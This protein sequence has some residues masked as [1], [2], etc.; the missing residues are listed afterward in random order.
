M[1]AAPPEVVVVGSINVDLVTFADHIPTD[2]ETITGTRFE[3]F[4]GGKGANQAV[5]AARLGAQVA[6]IGCVG[7]DDFGRR[8]RATL[9]ADG[10]DLSSVRTVSGVSTGV[11][12]ITVAANGAN[13]IVVI[14]GANAA[15][16][17]DD[18]GVLKD[19]TA[20]VVVGVLEVPAAVVADAMRTAIAQGARAVLTPAPVPAEGLAEHFSGALDIVVPNHHELV[21]LGG[22][23]AL[24]DL[25]ANAVIVT[26]G[27]DGA[28]VIDRHGE[29]PTPPPPPV[30]V[31]DTTGA[32]DAFSGSLAVALARGISI[33]DAAAY[34]VQVAAITV[35]K[36]GAQAS[37]PTAD[38]LP[39]HLRLAI[40]RGV[41]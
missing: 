6:M 22:A 19:A 34:A 39:S 37:Y 12:P 36:P 10:L 30:E 17:G 18:L 41:A 28:T 31:V 3:V 21:A 25:G 32:G 14:P 33:D 40:D 24:L 35:T 11:A 23:Q 16:V 27:A 5:M 26:R 1:S 7:D 29:R 20:K 8:A 38:Q 13:A 9:A 2:G 4:D 15:L